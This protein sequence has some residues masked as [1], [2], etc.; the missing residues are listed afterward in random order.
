MFHLEKLDAII[1]D[2]IKPAAI[3]CNAIFP[4][5]AIQSQYCRRND[6]EL[7]ICNKE[8][9]DHNLVVAL[10]K[11]LELGLKHKRLN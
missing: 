8:D 3:G 7:T 6:C 5:T 11:K 1:H 10:S 4:R 9:T 2:I